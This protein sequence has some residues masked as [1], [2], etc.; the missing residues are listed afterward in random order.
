MHNVDYYVQQPSKHVLL[1][2]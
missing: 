1:R 2:P